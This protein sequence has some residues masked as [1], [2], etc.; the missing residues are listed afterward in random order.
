MADKTLK[1][2]ISAKDDASATFKK[3]GDASIS[4]AEAMDRVSRGGK[5]LAGIGAGLSAVFVAPMALGAKAAWGQVD[6]VQKA[7][8]ALRAYEKDASKVDKTLSELVAYARSPEG[9]LF[10]RQELFAAAQGLKVA[11]AETGNLTRYVEI[12]S[13]AVAIGMTG[14]SDLTAVL[15]RV[16]A[17]GKLTG[18]DFDSLTKAGFQLDESLRNQTVSWEQLFAALDQGIPQIGDSLNTIEGQTIRFQSALRNL[19]LA[20][21]GVDR[22][23]SQFIAG[24]L[25]DQLYQ[26][27]G[28]ATEL[29]N[30][31]QPAAAAAGEALGMMG[32]VAGGVVS[33]FMT[34]PPGLQA[35]IGFMGGLAG[36]TMT[37]TG[38]FLMLLPRLIETRQALAGVGGAR[39]IL[40]ILGQIG[41]SGVASLGALGAVAGIAAYAMYQTYTSTK[42]LNAAVESL[43]A[44]IRAQGLDTLKDQAKD[45]TS[46]IDDLFGIVTGRTHD[47]VLG[48]IYDATVGLFKPET[49]SKAVRQAI[50]ETFTLALS[51]TRVDA[52]AFFDW[53]EE[54]V[55]A[56]KASGDEGAITAF[57][58]SLTDPGVLDNFTTSVDDATK[59][60]AELAAEAAAARVE[61]AD[62]LDVFADLPAA[63]D[64]LR[65]DG[66]GGLAAQFE[67]MRDTSIAA[68]TD[69]RQHY[70]DLGMP[71][72]LWGRDGI[73]PS[74][75]FDMT[76][77]QLTSFDAAFQR[78][79]SGM[80]KGTLDNAAI[81]DSWNAIMADGTLTTEQRVSALTNLS[82]TLSQYI[83]SA[84]AMHEQQ[85]EFLNDGSR[86]LD[87]WREYDR[88]L[89]QGARVGGAID[90]A[91]LQAREAFRASVD[92]AGDIE[93]AGAALDQAL[94]TFQ[95]IDAL[96][97]RSSAAGSI[98]ENLVGK[99]GEWGAIDDMLARWLD[100]AETADQATAARERYN[101]TVAAG[102][103]IQESDARVQGLLNDIRADQLPLLAEQQQAYED[104]LQYLSGLN[105]EEQRRA[106][107]LQ[108][109]SVQAQIATL[110]NTAYAAS[111]GEIPKEVATEMILEAANADAGLKSILLQLGLLRENA[112]G[113]IS[114]VFP[115]ADATVSA[116]N[117]V[118]IAILAMQAVAENK[119]TYQIAVELYGEEEAKDILGYWEDEA[120]K[121]HYIKIETQVTGT[122]DLQT[123][124]NDLKEVTLADGTV[125][126]VKTDV[127]TTGWDQLS[128]SEL[129]SKFENDPVQIPVEGVIKPMTGA[130]PEEWNNMIGPFPE[131][132]IPA[133]VKPEFDW[134]TLGDKLNPWGGGT[135]GVE[136]P[137]TANTEQATSDISAVTAAE[138]PPKTAVIL[139]DNAGAMS[140]IDATNLRNVDDKTLAIGG[141]NSAAMNAIQAVNNTAVNDKYMT[142]YA[143]TVYSS[144]GTPGVGLRHGGVP[145][146]AHGGI[147]V[148]LAEA[149]SELLH[150]AGGGTM[151]IYNHGYYTVPPMTYVSPANT[152]STERAS[153][154]VDFSG[155]SFVGTSRAEMDNWAET[156][157]VPNLRKVLQDERAGYLR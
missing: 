51:D 107:M 21:L 144:I 55:N 123:A 2:T 75:A 22:D 59:S 74:D 93:Q 47:G 80:S 23:T 141:E 131:I 30:N 119:T 102:Y 90:K 34:L 27:I 5:A 149:G 20:F 14:W 40:A 73:I 140:A 72:E 37:A 38:A 126:T 42:S 99:P 130:T 67:E 87:W 24:G 100:T 44:A 154:V 157:L 86:I 147:P 92:W 49:D 41:G 94:R 88:Q 6:A 151:P 58:S 112:D 128:A 48:S 91:L 97:Q 77:A 117:R 76:A 11:G 105:A 137:V 143:T 12:M 145:G 26:A 118:T 25:G 138:I 9:V 133:S 103:A 146:Y 63:L 62:F 50:L 96:G 83:D 150:F 54:R 69:V 122:G 8:V 124:A 68:L 106:L 28:T 110:Y 116:I 66:K 108:D 61:F 155:A 85:L 4:L 120:G 52:A 89:N 121:R 60:I 115:D 104:N 134:S 78:V 57:L 29:L 13:R 53:V 127:D 79:M 64:D 70:L 111:L 109:S 45:A 15:Q 16:G 125:V 98:A 43:N 32:A 18:D 1:V 113:T 19:G 129:A 148:E 17:T 84:K 135:A 132:E 139:G 46:A 153:I 82:L 101:T 95:E 35:A 156:S 152:R 56:L 31:M 114:V 10:Q 39:G 81:M 65:M 7:T 71:Q 33:A 142:I 136:I 3:V 36:V